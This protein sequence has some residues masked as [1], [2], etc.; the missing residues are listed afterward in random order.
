VTTPRRALLTLA[1]TLLLAAAPAPPPPQEAGD[2]IQPEPMQEAVLAASYAYFKAKDAGDYT[3]AYRQLDAD[4]QSYVTPD[5]F[6]TQAKQFADGAGAPAG[7]RVVKL[8]WYRDP[9]EAKRPGLYVAAD[10]TGQFA[11]LY[12]ICGYLMWRQQP[13]GSFRIVREEQNFVDKETAHLMPPERLDPLP[14]Q[15]GCVTG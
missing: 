13:D 15:L 11:N 7:R 1:T 2:A 4:M 9:A 6:R 8:T 10:Y 14:R 5:L 12:M 3:A